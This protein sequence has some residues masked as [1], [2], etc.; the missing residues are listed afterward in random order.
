MGQRRGGRL[1]ARRVS[2]WVNKPDH[3]DPTCLEPL[4]EAP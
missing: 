1:E 3:D 4:D 2:T